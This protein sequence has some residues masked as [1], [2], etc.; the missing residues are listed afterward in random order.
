MCQVNDTVQSWWLQ[1][2]PREEHNKTTDK[3]RTW[4][5]HKNKE[6]KEERCEQELEDETGRPQL[7]SDL[8]QGVSEAACRELEGAT[9]MLAGIGQ[10]DGA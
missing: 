8:S 5:F 2:K 7:E 3:N 4:H 1:D 10:G 6:E 9:G